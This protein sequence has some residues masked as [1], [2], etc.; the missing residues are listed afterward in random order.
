MADSIGALVRQRTYQ[1]GRSADL[2][3]AEGAVAKPRDDKQLAGRLTAVA[4]LGIVLI[5]PP[6]LAQFDHPDRIF[7][8]PVLWFYLYLVWAVLIGLVAFIG[9]RPR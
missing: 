4:A 3:D 9:G 6:M 7:G 1:G 2:E 8:V 5:V